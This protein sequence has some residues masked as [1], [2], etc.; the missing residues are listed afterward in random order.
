MKLT[1]HIPDEI[2]AE[3][4]NVLPPPEMG[5]LKAVAIDAILGL[6]SRSLERQTQEP[7]DRKPFAFHPR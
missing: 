7:S 3:Y 1:I 2:I 6:L 4:R 5:L